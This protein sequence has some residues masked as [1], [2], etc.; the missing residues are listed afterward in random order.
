MQHLSAN[1]SW[2]LSFPPSRLLDQEWESFN[3]GAGLFFD[4]SM[5]PRDF[6]AFIPSLFHLRASLTSF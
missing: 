1:F 2:P 3:S 4:D 5:R 6:P